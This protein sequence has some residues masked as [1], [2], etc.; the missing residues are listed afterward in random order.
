M[1]LVGGEEQEVV[2]VDL[3]L[4]AWTV[5]FGPLGVIFSRFMTVTI[6]TTFHDLFLTD[7]GGG[8]E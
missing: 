4:P 1:E 3:K 6:F 2:F 7:T 8:I 5:N